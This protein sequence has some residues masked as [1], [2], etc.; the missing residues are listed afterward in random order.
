MRLGR[1]REGS[2]AAEERRRDPDGEVG[3]A[4][5]IV[6]PAESSPPGSAE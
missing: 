5:V 2:E 3:D 6:H 1:Y 4:L